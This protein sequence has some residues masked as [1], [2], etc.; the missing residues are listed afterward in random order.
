MNF[1][2]VF[3]NILIGFA[4]VIIGNIL[5]YSLQKEVEK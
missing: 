2:D 1:K 3:K 4:S 5:Y